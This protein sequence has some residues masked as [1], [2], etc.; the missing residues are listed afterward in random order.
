MDMA[1]VSNKNRV[2]QSF[3]RPAEGV[4]GT[5]PARQVH[6]VLDA[7]PAPSSTDKVRRRNWYARTADMTAPAS[8]VTSSHRRS[9]SWTL[10]RTIRHQLQIVTPQDDTAA[11]SDYTYDT[12]FT[13]RP[14]VIEPNDDAG[15]Q[16]LYVPIS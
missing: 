2:R 4:L 15:I 16:A 14:P 11:S 7:I 8:P 3:V 5:L 12:V 6:A 1:S 10:I 9:T 13:L